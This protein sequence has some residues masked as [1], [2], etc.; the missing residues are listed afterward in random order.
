MADFAYKPMFESP[1]DDVEFRKLTDKHVRTEKFAGKEMLV[2][3]P[4]ALTLLANQAFHDISHLLRP[5]HLEQLAS[6]LDDPE[7]SANDRFVALDLL[8]NANISA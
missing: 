6:I 5:K 2:V 8:K 7:A 1:H 3:E 4:E